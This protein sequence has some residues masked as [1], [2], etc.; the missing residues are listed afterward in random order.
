M[1]IRHL[2]YEINEQADRFHYYETLWKKR[3]LDLLLNQYEPRGKTL[4]DYGCGRGEFLELAAQAGFSVKGTDLDPKC[5][6]LASRHGPTCKLNPAD[7]VAQF[8]VKSFDV[9]ACFHVLEHVDNPK[10]VLSSLAKMARTHVVLA[11]P[12]L[13]YLHRTFRRTVELSGVNE[14]HLQSWDHWHLLNL[15]QRHCGL[16]LVAWG[17]DATILPF[18]SQ[19]SQKLLGTKATIWLETGPFRRVFPFHGVSVLG[20][21]KPVV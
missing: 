17:T 15:A 16:E 7:P 21:F 11:V 12:N 14:G 20:L 6:E 9:V 4:L 13:R 5:V 1:S 10:H 3:G 18:L 2:P 19:C 8:G